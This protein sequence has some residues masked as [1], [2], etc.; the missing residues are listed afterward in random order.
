MADEAAPEEAPTPP[1]PPPVP[2][3]GAVDEDNPN[4]DGIPNVTPLAPADAAVELAGSPVRPKAGADAA[5]V[6]TGA[7]PNAGKLESFAVGVDGAGG[8]AAGGAPN[9][10]AATDGADGA[11]GGAAFCVVAAPK[12]PSPPSP[13][14]SEGTGAA[15]SPRPSLVISGCFFLTVLVMRGAEMRDSTARTTELSST[16]S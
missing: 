1:N 6:D 11:A 3:E 5:T 16:G 2:N 12:R 4:V 9:V 15:V 8:F 14:T 7:T 10:G 13:N